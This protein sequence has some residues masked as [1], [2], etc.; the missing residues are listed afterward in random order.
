VHLIIHPMADCKTSEYQRLFD[1]FGPLLSISSSSLIQLAAKARYK[2]SGRRPSPKDRH[3]YRRNGG[4]NLIHVI[5][6]EDG[7]KYVIRVPAVGW[8]ARWTENASNAFRSQVLT[9]RAIKDKTSMPIPEVYDFDT[10]QS[11]L[12]GAPYMV[13]SF[14]PGGTVLSKW[15]EKDGSTTLEERRRNILASVAKAMSQLQTF[16]FEKTG[17]LRFGDDLDNEKI[18]IGRCYD[19]D[20]GSFGVGKMGKKLN[21]QDFGPFES[22]KKYLQY[23]LEHL[24]N[25]EDCSALGL[26]AKKITSM[27]ISLL[28]LLKH[29]DGD[30]TSVIS[31]PDFDS[32]NIMVDDEGDVTGILDWDLVQTVPRFLGYCRYPEWITRDW[33][34]IRYEYLQHN[35]C[36][37]ENCPEELKNYRKW[38][39]IEMKK[40]LRGGDARF[41]T[42]SHIYEAVAIAATSDDSRLEVVRNILERIFKAVGGFDSFKFIEEVGTGKLEKE[43][44][45]LNAGL[46]ALLATQSRGI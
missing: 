2:I 8:G 17:S 18:E 13:M 15:F 9:M 34:P 4:Y 44:C 20:E 12:I 1:R 36:E 42:K 19:W 35:N 11:N 41:T 43:E 21:V 40:C 23:Q 30:E 3:L 33:D 26:G 22:S 14:I 16:T 37:R 31:L 7:I 6:F 5:E 39:E 25:G 38:Y 10:T 32:Q 24:S 46:K 27:M 45:R 29:R 28:P